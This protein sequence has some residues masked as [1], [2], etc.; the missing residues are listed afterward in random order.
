MFLDRF[1]D[2]F[3]SSSEEVKSRFVNTNMETQK[4]VLIKSL[5]Y[6]MF[7]KTRPEVFSATAIK[8]DKKHLNIKPHLYTIWLDSM[9]D[10]VKLTDKEF[11]EHTEIAWRQTMQPGIDYMIKTYNKS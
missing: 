3:F 7:A 1:Y 10:A 5:A 8:H 4:K 9:I 2:S 6:M 11:N